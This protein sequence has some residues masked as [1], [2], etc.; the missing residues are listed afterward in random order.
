M[1]IKG[2]SKIIVCGLVKQTA[3]K[4][5]REIN[6]IKDDWNIIKKKKIETLHTYGRKYIGKLAYLSIQ[7]SSSLSAL[8]SSS[9]YSEVSYI[10][11]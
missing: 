2:A 4:K 7:A 6:Y 10:L 8:K 1:V 11:P 5:E 9:A 3:K